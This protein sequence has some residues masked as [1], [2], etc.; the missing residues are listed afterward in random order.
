MAISVKMVT[1][2][3]ERA[4]SIPGR[5]VG[6]GGK[7]FLKFGYLYVSAASTQVAHGVP[8]VYLS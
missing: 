6:F 7:G 5:P 1:G 8:Q 4:D 2:E 3:E